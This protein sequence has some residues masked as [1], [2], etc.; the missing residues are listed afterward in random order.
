MLVNKKTLRRRL[1][2][3]RGLFL[4]KLEM[5][6]NDPIYLVDRTLNK[7]HHAIFEIALRDMQF[8]NEPARARQLEQAVWK[9]S[10]GFVI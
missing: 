2:R 8:G 3:R 1:R 5:C 7:A 4:I 6:K 9:G 10:F